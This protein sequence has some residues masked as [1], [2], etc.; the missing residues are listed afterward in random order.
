[1]NIVCIPG[2]GANALVFVPQQN[3]FAE[4][5]QV[6]GFLKPKK[7]ESLQDYC[8][9]WSEV[10]QEKLPKPYVL[11]GMSMGGMMAQE[12]SQYLDP[13]A[14]ILLGSLQKPMP[15]QFLHQLA[16]SLGQRLPNAVLKAIRSC[17]P[18]WIAFFEGLSTK[19]K[20]LIKTMSRQIEIDFFR[21]QGQAAAAWIKTG[22]LGE[23]RCP[24]FRA[25]GGKDTVLFLDKKLG[26]DDLFLPQARHLINLTHAQ[27]IN[28]FIERCIEKLK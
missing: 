18:H 23:Y 26:P 22:F 25:H 2:L 17:S 3:H 21:W 16:E 19:D 27:Q 1:M 14:L 4:R 7:K 5:L 8:M 15:K 6:P 13:Q 11:V 9:R 12:L 20:H 10:L 28:A 24:V